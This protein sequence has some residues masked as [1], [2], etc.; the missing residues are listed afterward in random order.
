MNNSRDHR[1]AHLSLDNQADVPSGQST[2][3]T[4]LSAMDEELARFREPLPRPPPIESSPEPSLISVPDFTSE[5]STRPSTPSPVDTAHFRNAFAARSHQEAAPA[6]NSQHNAVHLSIQPDNNGHTHPSSRDVSARNINRVSSDT[7][8]TDLAMPTTPPN[9]QDPPEPAFTPPAQATNTVRDEDELPARPEPCANST[10][11]RLLRFWRQLFRPESTAVNEAVEMTTYNQTPNQVQGGQPQDGG[12]QAQTQQSQPVQQVQVQQVQQ[13]QLVQQ[14]LQQHFRTLVSVAC[15]LGAVI[16]VLLIYFT[17]TKDGR[18][19]TSQ[20]VPDSTGLPRSGS[21]IR[22]LGCL[23]KRFIDNLHTVIVIAYPEYNRVRF[24]CVKGRL[25]S[26][27]LVYWSDKYFTAFDYSKPRLNYNST[28]APLEQSPLP[29]HTGYDF[30]G[31]SNLRNDIY[32]AIDVSKSANLKQPGKVVL[33]TGAGRGLGRSMAIQ[34]ALANVSAIILSART[35]SELDEV[36]ER[37]KEANSNVQVKKAILSVTDGPAIKDLTQQVGQDFGRL[38]ILINNAGMNHRW[39]P[40]G[41][42]DPAGYWQVL[43]VNVQ[44]PLLLTHAFLPLLVKTAEAHST[45]VNII[46]L[47]S[48]GAHAVVPG[49]SA[50]TIS[51][52]ALQ[53]LSEFVG[54]EYGGKG[55]NVVGI[56]PGGVE[57]KLAQVVKEIKDF[58]ID[59][60]ELCG[61]FVVW[62]SSQDRDWLNGRYLSATWD[63][64]ALERMKEDIVNGDKLKTL[65][66]SDPAYRMSRQNAVLLPGLI[67]IH[68]EADV[69]GSRTNNFDTP[70]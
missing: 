69:L 57:T 36:E 60:P 19:K 37:V 5:V 66:Q 67:M 49:G 16:F 3:S 30:V 17:V 2:Q 43:E 13:V 4:T 21:I 15:V 42:T 58:M 53:R 70:Q 61:G 9:G 46:N 32:P 35:G 27:S 38:D 64:E 41:E 6:E 52:L 28:M 44:G 14:F 26:S 55:V 54:L 22:S 48:I 65:Q 40:V 62:L 33:I 29:P 68:P 20:A 45:H 39:E 51:K 47:T 34:Y 56:H 7:P 24:A 12:M 63:V 50:Y 31:L 11:D 59:T 8:N 1:P 10:K 18:S 25:S 23:T